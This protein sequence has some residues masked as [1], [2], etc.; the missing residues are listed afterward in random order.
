MATRR[1]PDPAIRLRVPDGCRITFNDGAHGAVAQALDC[2]VGDF[3]LRRS[4][5]LWA[6]QLAVVVDDAAQGITD[7]VRG[8]DLLDST[9]RQIQ[10]QRALGLPNS[11]CPF[12]VAARCRRPKA[13]EVGGGLSRSTASTRWQRCNCYG[14]AWG[15]RHW[16]AIQSLQGFRAPQAKLSDL[17][18]V[19]EAS[20]VAFWAAAHNTITTVDA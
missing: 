20:P 9:P 8:A 5:G 13:V 1:R 11:I 6:Y 16:K 4:D 7:V 10:L 3:V 14:D 19:P 15:N 17:R 12:A 2:D 18:R